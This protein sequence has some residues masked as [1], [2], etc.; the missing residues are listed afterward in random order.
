MLLISAIRKHV[1][2]WLLAGS[3]P[4]LFSSCQ[5]GLSTSSSSKSVSDPIITI[6]VDPA[7]TY[8]TMEHFGASDA[9][10]CQF[11]GQWPDVKR[12]AIADLLFSRD[13]LPSGQPKGI[14]LSLWRF[15]I[16]A[17]TAEQGTDSGIRDE[18]RRAESFLN[19]DGTY[20]WNKQAGQVWFLQAAKQ[21]GVENFLAFPNSPPV[22][23]T[24]NGK[25][26]ASNKI[27]NLNPD[28][29]DRYGHY[30]SSVLK[31]LRTKT[32]IT[33]N[34]ISPVNEPQ[35]DW[36]DGGQEGS[37]FYNNQIAGITRAL[38][39]ALLVD[40]LPTKINVAEA[41]QLEFLYADHNRQ[42]KGQQARAFFDKTSPDYLGDLPNLTRSI[43]A[44]SYFTTSP[45]DKAADIRKTV[46]N[47]LNKTPGL[48]YWMSEYCI[49]GDNGGEINGSG[50]ELGIDPAL[51]VAKVI[52]TDLVNANASAWHWWL[53]I[54]PYNYKDGLIYIDKSKTDGRYQPSKMLWALGHYS[55]FIRPGAV[56]LDATPE[57]GNGLLVSAYKNTD[58]KLVI[59]AINPTNNDLAVKPSL[60]S[61]RL[62]NV[63]QYVTSATADL[64]P[65]TPNANRTS[66]PARSI[67]TLVGDLNS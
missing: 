42:G 57:S 14:G 35:W 1:T 51:Y 32:G 44:H 34:Y 2:R 65:A 6:R 10:A 26:Y 36:S 30:M 40:Q 60:L 4:L 54:S 11:V 3:L 15:N 49:L 7:K 5:T 22:A 38:S 31:G 13:F 28:Q 61:G 52:H 62:S 8:Q 56:R 50:K 18:W 16:G 20:N 53:A 46:L 25:G 64:T 66:I 23:Y 55:R 27:P 67:V 43:S 33:F 29:F 19:P 48:S 58:S 47:S 17:G 41:G 39:N 21:R 37:P 24:A 45:Y 63:R 59:V 12:N 9:W